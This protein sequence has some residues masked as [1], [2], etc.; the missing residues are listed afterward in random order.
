MLV[1]V[2][3][4]TSPIRENCADRLRFYNDIIKEYGGMPGLEKPDCDENGDY[5]PMQCS[6]SQ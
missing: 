2:C 4:G 6:G 1:A 3:S 5:M